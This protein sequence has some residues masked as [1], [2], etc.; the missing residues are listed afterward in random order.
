M[1][2]QNGV[3]LINLIIYL[4]AILIAL[5]ILSMITSFFFGNILDIKDKRW[6]N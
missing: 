1:K 2:N 6:I 5:V 4:A 3:S